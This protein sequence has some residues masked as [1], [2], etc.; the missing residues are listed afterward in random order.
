MTSD[1][2]GAAGRGAPGSGMRLTRCVQPGADHVCADYICADQAEGSA[3]TLFCIPHAGGN[4]AYYAKLG[5]CLPASVAFHPL[6][7]PGRGRRHQEPLRTSMESMTQDLAAHMLP[8]A[9]KGP[10]A[11]FGHSMGGLLALLCAV[12]TQKGGLPLP[13]ALFISAA[14]PPAN[15]RGPFF[16]AA[17]ARAPEDLWDYVTALGGVPQCV[18][19]CAELRGYMEP[20]LRADFTAVET[21]RPGPIDPLPVPITVF[22]GDHDLIT[23]RQARE[24]EGL[25]SGAF[26]IRTFAGNHFYLQDHWQDLADEIA[27]ALRLEA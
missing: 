23:E 26:R 11:L 7:L 8:L 21:W 4:A 16:A 14:A 17:A 24:W 27:R 6:E 10:Y 19:E 13:R 12:H 3:A 2:H 5:N 20:I 9:R 22:M 15:G 1:R 25:T 18:A